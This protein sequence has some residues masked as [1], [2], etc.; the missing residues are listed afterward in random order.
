MA[1]RPHPAYISPALVDRSKAEVANLALVA[2]LAFGV[3]YLAA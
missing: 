2:L 3:A 1:P